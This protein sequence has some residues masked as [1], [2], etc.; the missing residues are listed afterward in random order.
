M[1]G[2]NRVIFFGLFKQLCTCKHTRN[3]QKNTNSTFLNVLSDAIVRTFEV[4]RIINCGKSKRR[5]FVF[6]LTLLFYNDVVTLLNK[7]ENVLSNATHLTE[8]S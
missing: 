4:G 7:R 5:S 2:K 3:T 1:H 8:L 6:T